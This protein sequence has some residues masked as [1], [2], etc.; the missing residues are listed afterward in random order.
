L[1]IQ[2]DLSLNF[3]QKVKFFLKK[4]YQIFHTS[5]KR[6]ILF[7]L[8]DKL[9]QDYIKKKLNNFNFFNYEYFVKYNQRF[10]KLD[11]RKLNDICTHL[12][13][14][15][16]KCPEVYTKYFENIFKE[17][18]LFYKVNKIE[19]KEF[20]FKNKI[21]I[22][23]T[24]HPTLIAN[25]IKMECIN[26]KIPTLTLM[27]GGNFGHFSNVVPYPQFTAC[28]TLKNNSF[29]YFQVYTDKMKEKI[30]KKNFYTNKK[31]F[32]NKI[33]KIKSIKFHN[34]K[35]ENNSF[36]SKKNLRIGYICR[37]K[38][39]V[40]SSSYAKFQNTL[41]MYN[42][43]N[44]LLREIQSHRNVFLNIS[45]YDREQINDFGDSKVIKKLDKNNQINFEILNGKKI[46]ERSDVV[47]F[48]HFSTLLIE[49]IYSKKPLI[50]LNNPYLKLF[51]DQK[52]LLKKQVYF[53]ES[54]SQ[55]KNFLRSLMLNKKNNTF[56][57]K[58]FSNKFIQNYYISKTAQSADKL[59]L[60][61]LNK[62]ELK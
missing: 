18:N 44:E 57:N 38:L 26:Q 30:I 58:T 7:Y 19:I 59:I 15:K 62:S 37:A 41:N 60:N 6:N 32:N 53:I 51:E 11:K 8:T 1:P 13:N 61:I 56:L 34:L 22:F 25:T 5:K 12:R 42:N 9:E 48:E 35:F 33:L 28:N 27:H 29:N 17:L 36:N 50:Y 21:D 43:R 49:A 31:E 4:K 10:S 55:F 40:T 2:E 24:A 14:K 3:Q 20:L 47:I 16:F 46:I 23:I 54:N 52:K 45:T 39:N